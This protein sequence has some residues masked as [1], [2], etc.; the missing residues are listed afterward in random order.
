M[1]AGC[2]RHSIK[3]EGLT[4]S[5]ATSPDTN[6]IKAETIRTSLTPLGGH[7]R[8]NCSWHLSNEE[9]AQEQTW[10]EMQLYFENVDVE[11]AYYPTRPHLFINPKP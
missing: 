8:F 2:A 6:T 11:K 9:V 7:F 4:L 1:I 5:R 3:A 10:D